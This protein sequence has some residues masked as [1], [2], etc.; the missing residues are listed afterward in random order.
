MNRKI[1]IG[2]TGASG[3]IYARNMIDLLLQINNVE[4][5]AV[6][7]SENGKLVWDYEKARK[8]PESD[9][10]K[11]FENDNLF[12]APSS[13]SAMYTDMIIVP[14]SVGTMG[15]IAAGIADNLICR[16]ADVMLK[17]R[18]KLVLAVREAPYSLIHLRNMSTVTEA[19]GIIYPL[20]PFFYHH[21]GEIK[22][23]VQP[24]NTRILSLLGLEEP[25]VKWK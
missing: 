15:K 3:H 14:C 5:I 20:S 7:F 17:E 10:I 18:R 1:I 4:E 8:L 2:I 25:Q 24:L 21:P 13:G 11:V 12:A 9:K 19:G 23:I 6:V 16:A 22:D